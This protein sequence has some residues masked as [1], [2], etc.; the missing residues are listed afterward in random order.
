MS[1]GLSMGHL[2]PGH[3][4]LSAETL[5]L[6][7]PPASAA[8]APAGGTAPHA[9]LA[10]AL[11]AHFTPEGF[12][13]PLPVGPL[14][15][16]T[17]RRFLALCSR[18]EERAAAGASDAQGLCLSLTV[19]GCA[20]G[21]F[22]GHFGPRELEGLRREVGMGEFAW[23]TFLRLLASA[24]RGEGGC[25]AT[26]ERRVGGGAWLH[27]RFQ[28]EAASLVGRAELAQR[29]APPAPAPP[30]AE[31]YLEELQ[32]FLEGGG[33]AQRTRAPST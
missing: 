18:E 12:V 17:G 33:G 20:C 13:S 22:H 19:A 27:L 31:A 4:T 28:L 21:V 32:R 6:A 14:G 11:R 8:A 24:L 7:G 10:E 1:A 15:S 9:G 2:L 26:V 23:A 3:D 25:A 5:N 30:G 16:A 29:A